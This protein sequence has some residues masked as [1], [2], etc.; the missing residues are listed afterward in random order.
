M[1]LKS[2][3]VLYLSL[4]GHF[5]AFKANLISHYWLLSLLLVNIPY[6]YGSFLFLSQI[7]VCFKQQSN[8][9]EFNISVAPC[10]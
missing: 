6:V 7:Y 8:V 5:D 2:I 3:Y 1:L 9:L 4:E 10:A